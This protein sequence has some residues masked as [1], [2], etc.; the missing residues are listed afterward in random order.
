MEWGLYEPEQRMSC[1]IFPFAAYS[2][3]EISGGRT[4]VRQ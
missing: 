1:D 4:E 2:P 3:L